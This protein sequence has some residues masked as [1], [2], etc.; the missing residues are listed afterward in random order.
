VPAP[1]I[2]PTVVEDLDEHTNPY[3]L[4]ALNPDD[5]PPARSWYP[6]PWQQLI[7]HAQSYILNYMAF[8]DPFPNGIISQIRAREDM[9]AAF[10]TFPMIS[11]YSLDVRSCK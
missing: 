8:F 3:T 6:K 10:R 4:P 11:E 2:A 1:P 9:A 5:P 7:D